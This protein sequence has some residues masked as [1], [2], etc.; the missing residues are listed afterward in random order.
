MVIPLDLSLAF[1][2]SLIIFCVSL[3]HWSTGKSYLRI[4]IVRVIS[5][6]CS[7]NVRCLDGRQTF[8]SV[9]YSIRYR[10]ARWNKWLH[11]YSNDSLVH[12]LEGQLDYITCFCA[13]SSRGACN[14]EHTSAP[15]NRR[16]DMRLG[17]LWWCHSVDGR[18]LHAFVRFQ[19]WCLSLPTYI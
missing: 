17:Q 1:V 4:D 14:G 16:L 19:W 13:R 11:Q 5:A 10:C 3:V 18:H 8:D 12:A 7:S 2:F 9:N 6:P 15:H